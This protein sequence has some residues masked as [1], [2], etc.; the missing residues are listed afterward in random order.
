VE[1]WD[2]IDVG[3]SDARG[4]HYGDHGSV[5]SEGGHREGGDDVVGLARVADDHVP[6]GVLALLFIGHADGAA[7][8][9]AAHAAGALVL[10]REPDSAHEGPHRRPKPHGGDKEDE[11][12]HHRTHAT[13]VMLPHRRCGRVCDFA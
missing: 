11:E 7:A 8:R 3:S 2:S 10:H 6:R 9:A 1:S 5:H 4:R 13:A 12:D